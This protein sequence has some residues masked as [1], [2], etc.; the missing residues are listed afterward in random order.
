MRLPKLSVKRP[1]TTIMMML[2]VILLGIISFTNLKFELMPSINPPVIAVMTTYPG[3]GPEEINEMVTKPIEEVVSVTQGVKSIES[4]S[5]SNTSLIIAEYDWN[6]N[7]SEAREDLNLQLELINLTDGIHEPRVLKFDPSMIPIIKIALSN[8]NTLDELQQYIV[9]EVEPK[10]KSVE[11][12]ADVEISGGFEE[13]IKVSLDKEKLKTYNL[14][15][16]KV[17]Q[18]ISAN[19]L[20]YPGGVIEEGNQKINLRILG[21]INSTNELGLLPIHIDYKKNK[22]DK[23]MAQ[24]ITLKDIADIKKVK[25]EQNTIA[26]TNQKESVVISIKKEGDANTAEVASKV[27]DKIEKLK[28]E[29]EDLETSIFIDQGDVIDKSVSNVAKALMFGA[30]FAT[31]VILL[32]LRSF[33]ATMII[34]IA[35]PFSVITTFVLMYFTDMTLN[36][37]SLGGLA[38]G[39]GML[40]D[41]G[42]VVIEN[43]HRHIMLGKSKREAA[44]EGTMEIATAVTASTLTTLSVFL[45]VLFVDGIIGDLFKELSITVAFSLIASLIVSL[46]VVPTLS[47]LM[48]KEQEEKEIKENTFYRTTIEWCLKNRILTLFLANVVLVLS[49]V[50]I[51]KVGT[52]FMP[53]ADEGSFTINVELDEGTKIDKTVE[54]LK[55][56]EEEIMKIDEL[57]IVTAEIGTGSTLGDAATGSNESKAIITVNLNKDKDKKTKRI[58]EDLE[59]VLD[60]KITNA[61]LSYALSNSNERLSG[62]ANQIEVLLRGENK[63]QI[64][65]YTDNLKTSLMEEK[66]VEEAKSSLEKGK[67]EMRFIVN[68]E[69]ALKYGLTT[70]QVASIVNERIQGVSATKLSNDGAEI[71]VWVTIDEEKSTKKQLENLEIETHMDNTIKLKE[72]GEF[73]KEKGAVTIVRKDGKESIT[74]S[75]KYKD[76][77]MGSMMKAV[78]EKIDN[79]ID[80][81]EID[82]D[83]YKIEIS[84]GANNMNESFVD[85]GFA[86][87]LAVVLVYMVMASQFESLTQPII[88]MFTL[89]LAITGVVF[90]LLISGYA[91]GV[92]AFIGIIILAGI[93]VNNAIVFI[94]YTNQLRKEGKTVNNALIEAG[95]TRLKPIIMTAL[96]TILGLLPLA[97]GTGEGTE[98]QAPMAIAVIGGLLTSTLLTLIIIP[99][100][101]SLTESIKKLPK[102]ISKFKENI[103][104]L[105]E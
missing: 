68:K 2:L 54:K 20:S 100:V 62:N 99:V 84:G 13:E 49:I 29:N 96:T 102:K 27:R 51:P 89:P 17:V 64:E 22:S 28:E 77:D 88:I 4:R 42:I 43:I 33:R 56:I 18:M 11:G 105:T 47:S 78:N 85:L 66:Y 81:L 45:P 41:N 98:M 14:T 87:I 52:E 69:N 67:P 91:F 39:V 35:I 63:A 1:I 9:K 103:K 36:I 80:E 44:I 61:K 59:E 65:K 5:S 31:I 23:M 104:K 12:V 34:A 92:T 94:D 90:G 16:D 46:T 6:K 72:L 83:L 15:Q 71:N 8:G 30:L 60:E 76:K 50:A 7:I 57:S 55:E 86:L 95:I 21:K 38:L 48:S 58:M 26:R 79:L 40:V 37:M 74:L 3:A 24:V 53:I 10:L 75:I 25:K 97:I 32:F 19:N 73:K 70:Y 82:E 93:V 101:Y